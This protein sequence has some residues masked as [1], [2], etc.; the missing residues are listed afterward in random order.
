MNR[1]G[2]IL[3]NGETEKAGYRLQVGDRIQVEPPAP[4]PLTVE[5]ESIPLEVHY[6]DRSL[7]V[8]EKPAGM[9]VASGRG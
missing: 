7:A 4:E 2:A 8:I 1:R 6:E 5:A 9:V 3:V